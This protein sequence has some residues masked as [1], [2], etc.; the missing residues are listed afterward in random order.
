MDIL[1]SSRAHDMATRVQFYEFDRAEF[2]A[3]CLGE[4]VPHALGIP[5]VRLGIVRGIRYRTGFG[6]GLR[7]VLP[8]FTRA[9]NARL[10]MDNHIPE[11]SKD[12]EVPYCIWYPQNS[13]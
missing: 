10:I 9:L 12:D 4:S 7:G 13:I 6:E 11:I 8:I 1:Q 3:A 2:R 5:L